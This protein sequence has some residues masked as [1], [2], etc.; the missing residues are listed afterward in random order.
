MGPGV[1]DVLRSWYDPGLCA[2]CRACEVICSIHHTGQCAPTAASI[3]I[4]LGRSDGSI[5]IT[6]FATCDQCAETEG[7]LCVHS[8]IPGALTEALIHGIPQPRG[9]G[10]E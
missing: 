9:G 4:A 3:R 5:H 8:C 6:L 2:A 10:Q 7:L 1:I